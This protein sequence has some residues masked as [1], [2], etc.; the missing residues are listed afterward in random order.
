MTWSACWAS[1]SASET[2]QV[3]RICTGLDDEITRSATAHSRTETYLYVFLDAIFCKTRIGAHVVS[4]TAVVA[5]VVSID[6]TAR[7]SA[8]PSVIRSRSQLWREFFMRLEGRGLSGV[9]LAIFDTHSRLKATVAQQFT[10]SSWQ[11]GRV[12]LMRNIRAAVSS[13]A[14]AAGD[15]RGQDDFC[16]HR[17]A[18]T[19]SQWNQVTDTFAG[20]FPNVAAWMKA[21]LHPHSS[22]AAHTASRSEVHHSTGRYPLTADMDVFSERS[23]NSIGVR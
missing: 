1:D 15:G 21:A 3:S 22:I 19:A 10:E 5:T 16:A 7:Y 12:H 8:P 9:H 17:P 20:S 6:D 11:R 13:T 4:Q 23:S 14:R 18:K 2:S